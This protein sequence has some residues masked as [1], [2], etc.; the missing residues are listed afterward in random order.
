MSSLQKENENCGQYIVL[1]I[2]GKNLQCLLDTGSSKSVLSLKLAQKLK[3][4]IVPGKTETPLISANGASLKIMGSADAT[5]NVRG[6]NMVQKFVIVDYLFPEII[7]GI[8]FLKKNN[9]TINY[10]TQTVSFYE[11][12]V[13]LPLQGFLP[14]RHCAVMAQTVVLPAFTEGT[15]AV[16]LPESYNNM[17]VILEPLSSKKGINNVLIAACMSKVQK[18]VTNLKILNWQPIPVTLRKFTKM[19]SILFPN[20][21]S[22]ITAV[23]RSEEK[24]EQIPQQP[25]TVLDNFAQEFKL[26]INPSLPAEERYGFLNL[27]YT[28]KD[29]FARSLGDIK[30]YPHY[31][32]P[33]QLKAPHLTSY[34]RQYPLKHEEAMAAEAE[35]QQLLKA[36]LITENENCLFN[37]PVFVVKKKGGRL[38]FCTGF[39]K[40]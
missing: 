10:A 31:K 2:A 15:I 35:I 30:I 1:K 18:G 17:E 39:E 9:A 4:K 19:A 36:G 29:I 16:K 25:R 40:C 33:I 23:R 24:E 14:A 7:L 3:L 13:T 11:D 26:N 22:S 12:L 21:I 5:F 37:S 20:Q 34:T 27:C 8:N 32:L 6:L 28:Y 38:P